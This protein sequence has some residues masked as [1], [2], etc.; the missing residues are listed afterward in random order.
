MSLQPSDMSKEAGVVVLEQ[1]D[2]VNE[3]RDV[4][5]ILTEEEKKILKRATYGENTDINSSKDSPHHRLKTD[6]RLV[7]VLGACYAVA[8]L[9]RINVQYS[10]ASCPYLI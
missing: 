5:R 7:P 6:W 1:V 10:L 8:A 9:D 4:D 2:S 3:E